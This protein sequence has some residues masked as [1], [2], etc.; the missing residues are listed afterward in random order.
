[1]R[2]WT[3]RCAAGATAGL[4]AT[5][6]LLAEPLVRPHQR[7]EAAAWQLYFGSE[8][9]T[10]QGCCRLSFCCAVNFPCEVVIE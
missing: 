5:G 1:M 8:Y 6:V 4:L 10:C 2:S 9:N 7:V 3:R